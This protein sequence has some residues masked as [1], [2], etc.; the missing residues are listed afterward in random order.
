VSETDPVWLDQSAANDVAL[1]GGKG[2]NLA[3]LIR[4]GFHVPRGFVVTSSA[5]LRAAE[6]SGVRQDL[7]TAAARAPTEQ[8]SA[9]I[10]RC[11][12]LEAAVRQV[13]IPPTMREVI[14]ES[15]RRLGEAVPVAVRSSATAEDAG[16]TSFAGMHSTFTWVA[17]ER[18]LLDRIKDCWASLYTQRVIAYRASQHIT[19]EP[20]IAVVVQEMVD[21]DRAGVAFTADPATGDEASIVV[22]GALGLGEAVVSGQVEPDTYVIDAESFRIRSVRVGEQA[23]MYGRGPD[24]H[25]A[26]TAVGPDRAMARV[27]TDDEG[28]Q[29]ARLGRQVADL[30]GRPMDIEWA[31]A[32][33]DLWL[34]QARPIT[35][36]GHAPGTGAMPAHDMVSS[37]AMPA[38][39]APTSEDVP[40]VRG[41][42]AAAGVATGV[43]R[44]LRSPDQGHLLE[45]G[46]ILVAPMTNPDWVPT[47]RRAA[48]LVTDSGGTT[49][50][51]AI[52]SRELGVPCIVGTRTATT[53]LHDGDRITVDGARGLVVAGR[54]LPAPLASPA[55]TVAAEAPPPPAGPLEAPTATRLYVNLAMPDVAET[56][57]AQPVDG[58]GL[59]RAEFMLT[60]AL[61]GEH[62]RALLAR[63]EQDR[64]VKAMAQDLLEI[65]RAFMPRPVVYRTIDFRTNEFRGLTGVR[66]SSPGSRTR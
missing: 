12:D 13:D 35:T 5:F 48:A 44:V 29:V 4:A 58:V 30:Y 36:L 6:A 59:L 49:C 2:A 34:L 23:F 45:T 24:G 57:A 42:G 40:I 41:L 38:E 46:E 43:V 64:F 32:N 53:A 62:P 47:I 19:G 60:D 37:T 55:A 3:R 14:R 51:A 27:L 18:E 1:A 65:T 17:G 8:S 33:E 15:Y 31:F 21:A 39:T 16:D 50:H 9:L 61:H 7:R 11:E 26:R 63:G 20:A 28:V 22:E 56:V 54:T 52:V 25:V 10:D 66:T